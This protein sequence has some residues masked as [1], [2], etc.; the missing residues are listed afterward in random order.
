[1]ERATTLIRRFGRL[2]HDLREEHGYTQAQ[3]AAR[4]GISKKHLGDIE[5]GDVEPSL[6]ALDCI[7][8][9]FDTNLLDLLAPVCA[10]SPSGRPSLPLREWIQARDTLR[11]LA[12]YAERLVSHSRASGNEPGSR[13]QMHRRGRPRRS[14]KRRSG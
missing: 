3:L 13:P 11:S 6:S 1:M 7:A 10:S 2:V 4:A 5:R 12:A 9:A 14:S 8:R